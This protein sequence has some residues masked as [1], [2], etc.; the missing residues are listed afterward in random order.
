MGIAINSSAVAYSMPSLDDVA[1]NTSYHDEPASVVWNFNTTDIG[2]A[3][4]VTPADGFSM[5]AVNLG[6]LEVTGTATRTA[7][8]AIPGVTFV[9]L[10]PSGS[11]QAVEW[12]L[13]PAAGLTFPRP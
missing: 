10:R 12:Q 5:T 13:K 8:D 1:G 9:K 6:D 4:A 2:A 11:T 7:D 3:D